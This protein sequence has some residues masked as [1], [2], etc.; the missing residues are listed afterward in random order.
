MDY[1]D[2]IS[3]V[4]DLSKVEAA[5]QQPW[6]VVD[7]PHPWYPDA[8][9]GSKYRVLNHGPWGLA[10]LHRVCSIPPL[11]RLWPIVIPPSNSRT[12]GVML[13]GH[14]LNAEASRGAMSTKQPTCSQHQLPF[15][16]AHTFFLLTSYHD[17]CAKNPVLVF[18]QACACCSAPALGSADTPRYGRHPER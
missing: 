12:N 8:R 15:S 16:E 13:W 10:R 5:D 7:L 6:V 11:F 18:C 17:S 9:S 1:H 3:F 14:S 2:I 4:D